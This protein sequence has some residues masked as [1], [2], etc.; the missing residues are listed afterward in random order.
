MVRLWSHEGIAAVVLDRLRA[1]QPK[2]AAAKAR[3]H[4]QGGG[5]N[6]NNYY[7]GYG[8]YGGGLRQPEEGKAALIAEWIGPD[9]TE[10]GLR[11]KIP[12]RIVQDE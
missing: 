8:G 4:A 11:D 12:V 6:N 3:R 2:I 7:G 9:R 10:T 5:N 1:L